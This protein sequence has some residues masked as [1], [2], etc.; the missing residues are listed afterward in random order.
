MVKMKSSRKVNRRRSNQLTKKEKLAKSLAHK[1]WSDNMSIR[2]RD[3][4]LEKRREAN[5][6]DKTK[7]RAYYEQYYPKNKKA[8]LAKKKELRDNHKDEI[9]ESNRDYYLIFSSAIISNIF[10]ITS[11]F[12]KQL[13]VLNKYIFI[14]P[15]P[16]SSRKKKEVQFFLKF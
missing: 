9:S 7:R 16:P 12:N 10:N 3:E 1:Q 4:Y 11:K 14:C 15:F 6:R 2:E 8:I 5:Q 13:Y